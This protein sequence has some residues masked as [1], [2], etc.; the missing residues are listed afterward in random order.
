MTF[1]SNHVPLVID[2]ALV[3][4]LIICAIKGYITGFLASAFDL[5]GSIGGV[6]GAWYVSRHYTKT[7]FDSF[8]RD[9][10]ID[11][12]YNYLVKTAE[13]LGTAVKEID[14]G[15][16]L[17]GVLGNWFNTFAENVIQ[18]AQG[19]LSTM[20]TPTMEA[21]VYLVDE[22]VSPIVVSAMSL[23]I[24]IVCFLVVKIVC[25][26]L[27]NL[28]K[29]VNEVPVIGTANQAAGFVAGVVIGVVYIILLSFLFSIIVMVTKDSLTH[30]NGRILSQSIILRLTAFLNPFLQ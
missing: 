15:T 29:G 1:I 2:I 21:A 22:F 26:A 7:I 23:I 30:F 6:V 27:S 14:V 24:F 12:S 25:S 28:T 18:K 17:T 8:L 9:T 5:L 13:G 16:A 11:R 19:T 3:I 10:M 20:L 4:V